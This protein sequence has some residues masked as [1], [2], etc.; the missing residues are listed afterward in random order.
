[1]SAPVADGA[2]H[3][4]A[5]L[6]STRDSV[7]TFPGQVDEG[8]VAACPTSCSLYPIGG[9]NEF[10]LG[11]LGSLVQG[12]DERLHVRTVDHG[13]DRPSFVVAQFPELP[14][15]R[16]GRSD[17]AET[18]VCE[19]V[20]FA[21]QRRTLATVTGSFARSWSSSAFCLTV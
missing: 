18:L 15:E 9:I 3:G 6:M 14:A 19:M 17:V 12:E 16:D 5:S 4:P 7:L 8:G 1:M 20:P 10:D 13:A 11:A 2:A 21:S